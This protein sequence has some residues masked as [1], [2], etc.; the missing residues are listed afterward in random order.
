[1]ASIQDNLKIS[2]DSVINSVRASSLNFSCQEKPFPF[3]ITIRKS[4][5]KASHCQQIPRFPL[6]QAHQAEQLAQANENANRLSVAYSRLKYDL[7]D[8][9]NENESNKEFIASLEFKLEKSDKQAVKDLP[10]IFNMHC[11]QR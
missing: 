3:N 9:N 7:E 10:K 1:M 2:C 4:S 11:R 6:Q 8:A 5:R